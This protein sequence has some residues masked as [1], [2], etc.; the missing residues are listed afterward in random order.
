MGAGR[1]K[2]GAFDVHA[3]GR[4]VAGDGVFQAIF[5]PLG[6]AT[7]LLE[8]VVEGGGD[9]RGQEGDSAVEGG[10]AGG[11]VE[12]FGGRFLDAAAAGAVDLEVDEAGEEGPG[13]AGCLGFA[14]GIGCEGRI[15]TCGE[16]V[17]L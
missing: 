8:Q 15:F 4:C 16:A 14:V 12:G 13:D 2:E 7:D 5:N 9:E 10:G 3:E 17:G 6:D 11:L 1:E